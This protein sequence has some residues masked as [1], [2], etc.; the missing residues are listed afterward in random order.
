LESAREGLAGGFKFGTLAGASAWLEQNTPA[1]A[2]VF[3]TDWGTFPM[4]FYRNTHNYYLTGLDQTF[5]YEFNRD[6][7]WAWVNAT[8]GDRSDV[9]HVVH[10]LFGASYLLVEK[11]VGIIL[12]YVNRD[13]RFRKVYQDDEAII[14]SL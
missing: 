4:L 10:D 5:M 11:R 14:F 6:Q 12:R 3:Q 8:S 9:Y 7:Y 13:S 2:I 1:R